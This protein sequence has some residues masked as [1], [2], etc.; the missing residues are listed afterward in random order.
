MGK[1]IL[2]VAKLVSGQIHSNEFSAAL[3]AS[4]PLSVEIS[5]EEFEKISNQAKGLMTMDSAINNPEVAKAIKPMVINDIGSEMR[6]EAKKSIYGTIESKFQ[7]LGSKLGVPLEGKTLDEQ[8]EAISA[9]KVKQDPSK[10]NE[11]YA[12]LQNDFASFKELAEK[13][14]QNLI[15]EHKDSQINSKLLGHMST[16]PLAKAYQDPVIK[17]S[18]MDGVLKEVRSKAVL[19]LD[20][21]TGEIKLYNKDNPEMELFAEN[22]KVGVK[23]LIDPLMQPYIQASPDKPRAEEQKKVISVEN[24]L[25]EGANVGS[26]GSLIKGS[27][28]K[29]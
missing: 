5:D 11:E 12:K 24:G 18:L 14:K 17:N 28:E 9:A 23:D 16:V 22:K 13:E 1:T 15:K 26:A 2:D 19:K 6:S 8:I 3:S 10:T 21:S 20:D 4:E 29:F 25:P 27:G 7:N